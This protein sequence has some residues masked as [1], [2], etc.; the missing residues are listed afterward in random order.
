MTKE[1]F[2][3]KV[4]SFENEED[5][6]HCQKLLF[7]LGFNW[8]NSGQKIIKSKHHDISVLKISYGNKYN[9]D[10]L[11]LTNHYNSISFKKFIRQLK[12]KKILE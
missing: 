7:S 3:N 2:Y 6:V 12:F 1:M 9:E 8:I 5:F 10:V 11:E 4:F